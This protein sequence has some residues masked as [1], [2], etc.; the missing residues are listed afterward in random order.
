M[1]ESGRTLARLKKVTETPPEPP[2]T[3]PETF[4]RAPEPVLIC[5]QLL[6]VVGH[7]RAHLE[8]AAPG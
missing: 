5:E 3:Q 6:H 8:T 7:R 2:L 1:I 4:E